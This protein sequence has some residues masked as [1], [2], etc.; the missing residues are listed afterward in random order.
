[1]KPTMG[2]ATLLE[3]TEPPMPTVIKATEPSTPTFQPLTRRKLA[4]ASGVM[5]AMITDRD[6]APS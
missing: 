2:L 1:M 3:S 4:S 5:K 6:C